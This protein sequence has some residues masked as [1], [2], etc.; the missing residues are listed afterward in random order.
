MYRRRG[1]KGEHLH[2]IPLMRYRPDP[3]R[4]AALGNGSCVSGSQRR[5]GEGRAIMT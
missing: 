1:R 5:E 2:F 3:V 4:M